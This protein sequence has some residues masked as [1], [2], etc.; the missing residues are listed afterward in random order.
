MLDRLIK[1]IDRFFFIIL[2]YS[3]AKFYTGTLMGYAEL[4]IFVGMPYLLIKTILY[5]IKGTN[6]LPWRFWKW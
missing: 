1:V 6:F 2:L 3:M 4:F 5:I